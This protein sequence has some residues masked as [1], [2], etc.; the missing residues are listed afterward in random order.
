MVREEGREVPVEAVL[1]DLDT[2][3]GRVQRPD[4][5]AA[6]LIVRVVKAVE[7]ALVVATVDDV[8][9]VR[10]DGVIRTFTAGGNL[11]VA[12]RDCDTVGAMHNANRRVVLLRAV[13]AIGKVIVRGNSIELHG[14][15]VVVRRP[16]V[17]TV[18]RNLRTT[19]VGDDHALVVVR[20]DPQVVVIAVRRIVQ[21][22][23]HTAIRRDGVARRSSRRPYSHPA[24]RQ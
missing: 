13:D 19:I 16:A 7:I 15:L 24:S 18:G 2:R 3:T 8:V 23:R 17:A 21:T 11:P 9:V 1:H 4:V 6:A 20:I 14:R 5:D 10:I 22:E 12:F